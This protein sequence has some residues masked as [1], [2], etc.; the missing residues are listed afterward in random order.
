MDRHDLST[1][2]FDLSFLL[3]ACEFGDRTG[4]MAESGVDLR[5]TQ[6]RRRPLT[7]IRVSKI[8]KGQ[9]VIVFVVLKV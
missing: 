2:V 8:M 9:L 7:V 4:S 5:A 6:L 3:G 1:L